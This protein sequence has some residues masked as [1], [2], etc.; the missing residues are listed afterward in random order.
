M[1]SSP[2]LICQRIAPS[3]RAQSLIFRAVCL[4]RERDCAALDDL[5]VKKL[6]CGPRFEP[7][8]FQDG[9]SLAF[10]F[11]INTGFD[12]CAHVPVVPQTRPVVNRS[13]LPVCSSP[14]AGGFPPPAKNK[15]NH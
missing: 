3:G 10:Q 6:Q 15:I 4:D 5:F 8:L 1:F 2:T 13:I 12:N 11:G 9:F 7:D 14:P